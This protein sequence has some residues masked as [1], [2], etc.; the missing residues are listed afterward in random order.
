[1]DQSTN[2]KTIKTAMNSDCSDRKLGTT[3]KP[4]THALK[5]LNTIYK[6]NCKSSWVQVSL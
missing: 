5:I 6:E 1:L 4:R 3:Q 2:K